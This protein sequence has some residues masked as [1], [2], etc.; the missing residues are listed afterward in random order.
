MGKERSDDRLETN[1]KT[2]KLGVAK[3]GPCTLYMYQA[4]T[5]ELMRRIDFISK[6]TLYNDITYATTL[7]QNKLLS[8]IIL[9]LGGIVGEKRR[10]R[11]RK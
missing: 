1:T 2:L 9:R 11:E 7:W 3:I 8:I 4:G 5:F 6:T 10:E